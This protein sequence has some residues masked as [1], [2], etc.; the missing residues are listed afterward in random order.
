MLTGKERAEIR[1]KAN[2]METT[3]IV[4]KSGI[5]D[6]LINDAELQ[7]NARELIKGKVLE[8]SLM[9]AR[10]AADA[11]CEAT[12]AE[13]IQVVGNKFV[14]YRY[15]AKLHQNAG[16]KH[17]KKKG[18]PVKAG[19]KRRRETAQKERERRNAFFKEKAIEASIEKSRARKRR[20]N[21][22]DD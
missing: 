1:S 22:E 20:L 18:N 19:I 4:G 13:G 21:H 12:G 5:T 15:S 16:V 3:L 7:L 8:T 9:S 10:E 17:E 2:T 11:L 6:A 14:I